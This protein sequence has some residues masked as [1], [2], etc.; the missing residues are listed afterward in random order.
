MRQHVQLD[1]VHCQAICS[2][3]GERLRVALTLDSVEFLP[4]DMQG[5]IDRLKNQDEESPS[6]IPSVNQNLGN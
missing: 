6:I 2:E 4:Q 1:H 5:Q 3:I